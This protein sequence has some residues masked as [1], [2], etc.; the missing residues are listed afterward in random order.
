ML[1]MATVRRWRGG[2]SDGSHHLDTSKERGFSGMNG[3][4]GVLDGP[5]F[6]G[7]RFGKEAVGA[8]AWGRRVSGRSGSGEPNHAAHVVGEIDETD[9]HPGPGE[10][11]GAHDQAHRSLLAFWRAKTCSIQART[12]DETCARV[13]LAR[14]FWLGYGERQG[15]VA[16]A[17][18]D[19][20][21]VAAGPASR[22][23]RA[24]VPAAPIARLQLLGAEM[25]RNMRRACYLFL[26]AGA[27]TLSI[28][29]DS[30][31]NQAGAV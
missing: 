31:V 9:P 27:I 7:L 29:A 5:T 19:D 11:N 8:A 6:E 18:E 30:R 28:R 1:D 22:A 25:P 26:V 23:K 10:A 14:R 2:V 20:D 21:P 12:S 4:T 13:V 15:V 16:G 17:V 24:S 3:G